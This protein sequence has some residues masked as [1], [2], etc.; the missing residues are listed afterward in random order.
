MR[1]FALILLAFSQIAFAQPK[2]LLLKP[3][4]TVFF[5]GRVH[6]LMVAFT[7]AQVLTVRK[8]LPANEPIYLVIYTPGG[9]FQ[10]SYEL[11]KALPFV[12][13]VFPVI[14]S[15]DSVGCMVS[16]AGTSKRYIHET[17]HLLFH[18]LRA[19]VDE[20]LSAKQLEEL[21]KDVKKSSDDFNKACIQRTKL[22]IDE[23]EARIEN[24]N[25]FV[26]AEE[27]LKIGAADEI[28]RAKC[29]P[30][31]EKRDIQVQSLEPEDGYRLK[32]ICRVIKDKKPIEKDNKNGTG[33]TKKDK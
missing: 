30:E 17:G 6:A 32:N 5:A 25:W 33:A 9:E 7:L 13:N 3:E 2:E 4:N 8:T 23:Y 15:A 19:I 27:A 31:L 18:E 22:K 26:G 21:T 16:Q 28:V 29:S 1:N 20:P 14:V 10:S 24:D 12:E 11:Y